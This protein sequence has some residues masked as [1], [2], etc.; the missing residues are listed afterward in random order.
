[1]GRKCLYDIYYCLMW[2][3]K[4]LAQMVDST[5]IVWEDLGSSSMYANYVLLFYY[6]FLIICM[7]MELVL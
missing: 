7:N 1:M 4:V 6:W 5:L 2:C 3:G